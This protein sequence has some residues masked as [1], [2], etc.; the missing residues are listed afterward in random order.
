MNPF[1]QDTIAITGAAHG[2]GAALA[3]A[4]AARGAFLALCDVD[5]ILSERWN[6]Q[7]NVHTSIFDITDREAVDAWAGAVNKH[8]GG[9]GVLINNAGI[10]ILASFEDHRIEDWERVLG[11]NL[12]GPIYC[13]KAFLPMLTQSQGV[14][15]NISSAFGIVAPPG[16]A[17]YAASKYALRGLSE[18]LWEEL[19]SEGVCVTSVHPGGISTKIAERGLVRNPLW[20]AHVQK[21]IVPFFKR[22][23]MPADKAADLILR[24]IERRQPR[25]ILGWD[26]WVFDWLKRLFPVLGNYLVY[27]QLHRMFRLSDMEDERGRLRP[28]AR[29]GPTDDRHSGRSG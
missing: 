5:P 24:A 13:T 21:T 3:D 9:C 1:H 12:W 18:V 6:D 20:H 14:I 19:R 4:F 17:A 23:A 16:Q 25:L 26:S 28:E 15:V 8:F 2:L 22:R 11:I 7:D 10:T 29:G 27:R